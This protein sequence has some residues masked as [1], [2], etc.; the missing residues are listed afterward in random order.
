MTQ[1]DA[2]TT[3]QAP[4]RPHR[5]RSPF[6]GLLDRLWRS[7][8]MTIADPSGARHSIGETSGSADAPLT[9]R[10]NH[11]CAASRTRSTTR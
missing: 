3:S 5:G 7:G 6:I 8:V 4:T 1:A 9:W 11:W 2:A 10:L